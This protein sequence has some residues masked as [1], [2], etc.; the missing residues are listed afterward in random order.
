MDDQELIKKL[1]E[2]LQ[3]MNPSRDQAKKKKLAEDELKALQKKV[4]LTSKERENLIA[5]LKISKE[6]LKIDKEHVKI[7]DKAIK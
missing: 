1:L 2:E 3:K 5:Q 7:I 4:P 6:L